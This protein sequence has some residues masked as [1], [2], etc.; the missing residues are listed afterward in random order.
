[1]FINNGTKFILNSSGNLSIT[2]TLT[3]NYSDDR[4]KENKVNIP[5]ATDKLKTLNGFTYTPNAKAQALGFSADR[6]LGVS[7]QEVEAVLPEAV[8][9]ADAINAPNGNPSGAEGGGTDYKTVQYE[10]LV[11]L[12]IESIKELEARIA[13][14]EG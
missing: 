6:Q 3:Q 8:H 4:L 1:M 11:P 9:L 7:A 14:L 5:N 13:T 12:L 2:G 10:K